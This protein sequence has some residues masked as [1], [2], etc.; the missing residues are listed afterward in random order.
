MEGAAPEW[1][2]TMERVFFIFELHPGA[3]EE[4][5]RRHDTIWPEM[6]RLLD[7]AGLFD[8]SIFS[9]GTMLYGC[10]KAEPDWATASAVIRASDVQKRWEAYMA[11]LIAWQLDENNQLQTGR[12]VFRHEGR[13][14]IVPA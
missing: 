13:L 14:R 7:E 6:S 1:E 12:E 4:Y 11:D 3:L 9:R 8:Y 2:A 10:F 5:Q